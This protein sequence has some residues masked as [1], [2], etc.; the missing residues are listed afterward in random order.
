M[1][2]NEL[3]F[4]VNNLVVATKDRTL[5]DC[6]RAASPYANQITWS[7][8]ME[9]PMLLPSEFRAGDVFEFA[10]LNKD[11]TKYIYL[12]Q[13]QDEHRPVYD[14]QENEDKFM[15]FKRFLRICPFHAP[16][17]FTKTQI[18]NGIKFEELSAI[19]SRLVRDQLSD[20]NL[21]LFLINLKKEQALK[22]HQANEY[23]NF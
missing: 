23:L 8:D 14:V 16:K 18:K 2:I 21:Q 19:N 12:S 17:E 6:K 20:I 4:D 1:T 3:I 13:L 10:L 9:L 22:K 7:G 15:S 11:K 5:E